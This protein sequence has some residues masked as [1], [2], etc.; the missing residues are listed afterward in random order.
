MCKVGIL[1]KRSRD[2]YTL[3]PIFPI[4]EVQCLSHQLSLVKIREGET[5]SGTCMWGDGWRGFHKKELTEYWAVSCPHD[6]VVKAWTSRELHL[7]PHLRFG[8][9]KDWHWTLDWYN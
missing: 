7:Y 9:A 8:N 2:S 5:L 3:N 6:V 4:S 1:T